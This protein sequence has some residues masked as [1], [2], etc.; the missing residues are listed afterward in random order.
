M[1]TVNNIMIIPPPQQPSQTQQRY[2]RRASDMLPPRALVKRR[3]QLGPL[4]E[5]SKHNNY[6]LSNNKYNLTSNL[7]NKYRGI[8]KVIC[9]KQH[10]PGADKHDDGDS[11][12]SH[13]MQK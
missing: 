4:H 1:A 11:S 7:T 8:K 6:S 2:S 13:S 3:R 9:D 12:I 10:R 5:T